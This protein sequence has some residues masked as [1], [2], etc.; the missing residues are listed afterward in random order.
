MN[1]FIIHLLS[2]LRNVV[3]VVTLLIIY[4]LHYDEKWWNVL[5]KAKNI[6]VRVFNLLSRVDETRFLVQ[7]ESYHKPC[8]I[9]KYLDIKNSSSGKCLFV[10]FLKPCEDEKLNATEASLL[11]IK[12]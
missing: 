2:V 9:D 7:H 11:L 5:D 1:L 4:V 8:K 12:K 3:E 10:Q 6:S